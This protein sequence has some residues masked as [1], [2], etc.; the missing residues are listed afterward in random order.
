[1]SKREWREAEAL[2]AHGRWQ[3][4]GERYAAIV[5]RAKRVKDTATIRE[6][7]VLAPEC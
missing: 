3:E 5:E 4:A 6:A 2:A 1:M 7:A